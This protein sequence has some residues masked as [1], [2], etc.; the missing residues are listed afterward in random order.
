MKVC[1]SFLYKNKLSHL[2]CACG[3][4]IFGD[5]LS[6]CNNGRPY[7]QWQSVE[8]SNSIAKILRQVEV[9]NILTLELIHYTRQLYKFEQKN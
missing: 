1:A 7:Y 8:F 2:L 9:V 3:T 6:S 4:L 5:V